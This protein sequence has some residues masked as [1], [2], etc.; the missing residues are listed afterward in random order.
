MTPAGVGLRAMEPVKMGMREGGS[1][2]HPNSDQELLG[3]AKCGDRSA[4]NELVGRHRARVERLALA[5]VGEAESA[6]DIAQEGFLRMIGSLGKLDPEKGLKGWLDRVVVN[7]AIDHLRRRRRRDGRETLA[8]IE[9][10]RPE[11][12][13]EEERERLRERVYEVLGLMPVKY[14]T[15]LVLRDI[16][17]REVEEIAETVGRRAGTVRWRLSVGR[18]MFRRLW[19]KRTT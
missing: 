17:G 4:L 9:A 3:L 10:T 19:G 2:V 12:V 6:R 13:D 8:K 5:V 7:L 14:R 18:R 11:E 1:D 15:V 16:E